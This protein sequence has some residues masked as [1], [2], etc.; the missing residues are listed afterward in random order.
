MASCHNDD[1]LEKGECY[2]LVLLPSII[3]LGRFRIACRLIT[4]SGSRLFGSVV[5][6]LEFYPDRPVSSRKTGIFSSAMLHSFVTV[7]MS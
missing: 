3:C 6:V 4:A 7:I 1:F 5:R 2:D